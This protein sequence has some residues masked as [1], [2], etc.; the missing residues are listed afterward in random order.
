MNS[1]PFISSHAE[2]GT[3]NVLKGLDLDFAGIETGFL[4]HSI[5][6]YPAKYIPQI[7]NLLIQKLSRPGDVVG[8]IFCGS[9]TTLVEALSLGRH[10]VGVDANPLA[11]MISE[12][13]TAQ[14]SRSDKQDLLELVGKAEILASCLRGENKQQQSLWSVPFH[15]TFSRPLHRAIP[16][17]F[18][19]HVIEELAELRGWCNALR[20]RC[21]RTVSLVALSSI[22]VS[23]SRQDSDTRYVRREKKIS[24][25]DTMARFSRALRSA[26]AAI[27]RRES[28]TPSSVNCQIITA[29]VLE[30]PVLPLLDLM[31]CSPPY[32]NAYSYHLYHMTR[33][34]WLGMDQP[35]FKREEIGSH[36]K[37]SSRSPKAA[38]VET[39]RA[40]MSLV[41][42]WLQLY[43]KRGGYACFVIGNSIIRGEKINNAELISQSARQLGYREVGR[44]VRRLQATKKAFNPAIGKIK[45]ETV[46]VLQN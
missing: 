45:D 25:G 19:A 20:N 44:T 39:F 26:I 46:L 3:R 37:Y 16:F 34:L 41:M 35:R 7:P 5:H 32:P 42:G 27:E 17:W 18:E 30:R 15:S 40:E 31:V 38:S 28:E 23:V 14:L 22:I 36:R 10:A 33:M 21:S 2:T 29:N 4:T 13:K 6:P 24:P 9:G 8:D 12:A 11:C 43:L 1:V